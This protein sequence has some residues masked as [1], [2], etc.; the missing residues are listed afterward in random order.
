MPKLYHK[1]PSSKED[2]EL[3]DFINQV[4]EKDNTFIKSDTI[5]NKEFMKMMREG[6]LGK[7]I[8]PSED[9]LQKNTLKGSIDINTKKF[10]STGND[11]QTKS[12]TTN[13]FDLNFGV[14]Q[15]IQQNKSQIM[16]NKEIDAN[17]GS[18]PIQKS[19]IIPD[20]ILEN[21]INNL[22]RERNIG[23]VNLNDKSNNHVNNN[24]GSSQS[25]NNNFNKLNNINFDDLFKHLDAPNSRHS[26]ITVIPHQLKLEEDLYKKENIKGKLRCSISENVLLIINKGKCENAKL[27]GQ[28]TLE[29]SNFIIENKTF[30]LS[31]F[32]SHWNDNT[33]FNKVIKDNL[34]LISKDIS[35]NT[36]AKYMLTCKNIK[37]NLLLIDYNANFKLY[38]PAVNFICN[39]KHNDDNKYK[40]EL[41][42]FNTELMKIIS[43]ADMI[44]KVIL[45]D[46]NIKIIKSTHTD[47]STESNKI[48]IKINNFNQTEKFL[49]GLIFETFVK[50]YVDAVKVSFRYMNSVPSKTNIECEYT[51]EGGN[52]SSIDTI[53]KTMVDISFTL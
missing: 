35:M 37:D 5:T 53:K 30:Y 15:S 47:Y 34:T 20:I 44:I 41:Q 36:S 14:N 48:S 26:N 19:I 7:S 17:F 40:L 16:N 52:T 49:V 33:F 42:V 28:V 6:S 23:P 46:N 32:N 43:K 4:Q 45:K 29:L 1:Q 50:E 25:N 18:F 31:I 10:V 22:V 21:T 51:N 38:D 13:I 11:Y 24:I 3:N 9:L 12:N 39:G 8:I 2:K 27:R